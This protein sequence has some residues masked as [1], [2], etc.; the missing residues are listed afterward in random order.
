[1]RVTVLTRVI[2]HQ[3][4]MTAHT[5]WKQQGIQGSRINASIIL[6]EIKYLNL[7]GVGNKNSFCLQF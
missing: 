7:V 2:C 4:D 5:K 1:M 3:G 6:T